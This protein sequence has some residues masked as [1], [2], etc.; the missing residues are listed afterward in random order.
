MA[1]M[2]KI[3]MH[4]FRRICFNRKT[5]FILILILT[6]LAMRISELREFAVQ[7]NYA[8][9]V[10]SLLPIL[11]GGQLGLSRIIFMFCVVF[12]LR[13]APFIDS[14]QQYIMQR[15]NRKEW[16]LSNIIFILIFSLEY[17]M[18]IWFAAILD[19][20]PYTGFSFGWG[21]LLEILGITGELR[22]TFINNSMLINSNAMSATFWELLILL[23]SVTLL[24]LIIYVFN[25]I[26]EDKKIGIVLACFLVVLDGI[27]ICLPENVR[28]AV[29]YISPI[30]L[31]QLWCL[32]F[33]DAS[34]YPSPLY[35]VCELFVVNVILVVMSFGVSIKKD[36]SKKVEA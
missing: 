12:M 36:F 34:Y 5:L 21:K 22:Y 11:F 19:S 23:F 14:N 16:N 10:I 2:I 28:V 9:N 30:S 33:K 20:M 29:F 17:V 32:D 6:Q 18:M 8:I 7:Y 25:M 15:M 24:G 13:E 4:N 3:T 35:A 27:S 31:Q 26:K 1:R